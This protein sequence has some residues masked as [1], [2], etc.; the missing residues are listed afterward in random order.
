MLTENSK[1]VQSRK[2]FFHQF[3]PFKIKCSPNY[4]LLQFKYFKDILPYRANLY[5]LV[6]VFKI[7]GKLSGS[8]FAKIL[9]SM[10]IPGKFIVK[11]YLFVS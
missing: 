3:R 4:T 1:N 8:F 7:L 10:E 5:F 6:R 9:F 2:I 11:L